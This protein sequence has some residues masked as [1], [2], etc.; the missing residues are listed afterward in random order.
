MRI[1][2]QW[3]RDWVKIPL[4]GE[5]L[6]GQL[7]MAGL[8]VDRIEPA[9]GAFSGVVV[10]H[11]IE[12][13][14][15]PDADKLRVAT[16]EVGAVEPLQIVCGAPNVRIGLFAPTALV[17]AELPGGIAIER[18]RLRGVESHG[19]L[20][21]A[22]E[23]GLGEQAGGLLELPPDSVPGRD[24]R[25]LLDLDDCVIEIDLT[26]NRGDCLSIAGIARELGVL[27][28]LE[29]TPVGNEPVAAEIDDTFPV[30]L[31]D[32]ADCP[33]YVGRVI[34]GVDPAAPTPL[35]LVERL[36]RAGIRSLGP[37][38]DVTNYVMLELGQPLHAFDLDKLHE[39]IVVRRARSGERLT[40]LN[41]QNVDLDPDTLLI[42]D[43]S[44]PIALAGIMGGASTE[45]DGR[46]RDVFLESAF[47]TPTS[48]TGRARRYGLHTDASHR[49]ERGVDPGL[50]ARAVERATRLLI[51]IAGGRPG[52]L[53]D[54]VNGDHLPRV[55]GIRLRP[56]RIALLLGADIDTAEVEDILI[57]L[58]MRLVADNDGWRV[59]PPGFRFDITL[60]A[61]LIE[62]VGRVHGYDRIPSRRAPGRLTPPRSSEHELELVRLREALTQRG[63]Q[64][65]ISY[66][67]V[68][69][70]LQRLVDPEQPPVPLSNPISADMAVMRTSIWPGL[71]KTLIHNRNRQ[72]DRIRLFETGLNFRGG[73]DALAQTDFIAGLANGPALPEQWADSG[74]QVDFYD[75]KGDVEA[76]LT[77]TGAPDEYRFVA[78]RHPALHPGQSACIE[79][80][81]E[82]VGWLGALH[83]R[84]A[85][86]LELGSDVFLFELRLEALQ[87]AGVP[88]ARPLSRFPHS[89]RDLALVVE[90]TISFEQLLTAIHE[91]GGERLQDVTLFDVYR[92]KGI[93]EGCKSVAFGLI[94]QDFSSNLTDQAVDEI[95]AGIITGLE[96]RF[97]AR[98]RN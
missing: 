88:S 1:S 87:R 67:F 82:P 51:E 56:E 24:L 30:S 31:A 77:L 46:T 14:P 90:E 29:V 96:Q 39:R 27:N 89:R 65:I 11:V 79:R 75:L 58:G 72:Q 93:P 37:L 85:W 62:E 57:R 52:P 68:D 18:T 10:G 86:H 83:P 4:S 97:D 36:R 13:A 64:E 41:E 21:S 38:V 73:L 9:S 59:M 25:D 61:D 42:T 2:E 71:L 78:A 94:L 92:G 48:I 63:Y 47:F 7:T 8:E 35:W 19:M 26:P 16:V 81:G 22:R 69:P 32:P 54:T 43:A 91:Y 50:Q 95:V 3:L 84:L 20:C 53:T 23:L 40:L 5:S 55:P 60:E 80:A 70:E 34:R 76:L 98:L 6:A 49:F 28:R 12:L 44:G 17:G 74:R 66:S 15:H 45:C 33:R